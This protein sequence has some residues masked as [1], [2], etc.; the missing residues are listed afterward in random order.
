MGRRGGVDRYST[1]VVCFFAD[2]AIE[3]VLETDEFRVEV[4]AVGVGVGRAG[5]GGLCSNVLS[6]GIGILT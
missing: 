3:P 5:E 2:V 4:L 6:P 1:I